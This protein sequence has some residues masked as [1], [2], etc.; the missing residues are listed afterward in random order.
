MSEPSS[1]LWEL[2]AEVV[3]LLSPAIFSGGGFLL[4]LAGALGLGP[5]VQTLWFPVSSYQLEGAALAAA[6]LPTAIFA[7]SAFQ[8]LEP[9]QGGP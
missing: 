6:S 5:Q 1:R 8:S 4:C 3:G 7:R 9:A 2:G